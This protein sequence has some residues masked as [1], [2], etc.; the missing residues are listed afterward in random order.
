MAMNA[1]AGYLRVG[2]KNGGCAGMEYVMDYADGAG[3]AGRAWWRTRASTIVI[4]A[5]VRAVPAGQRRSTS[6]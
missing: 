2:V 3:S 4:D 5:K 6:K 1:G